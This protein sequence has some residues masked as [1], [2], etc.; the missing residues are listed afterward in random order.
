M[1]S[2]KSADVEKRPA[3]HSAA[4]NITSTGKNGILNKERLQFAYRT[5][6]L[7]RFIDEK[8]MNLLKQG[9]IL[10]HISGP[11][12]EAAQVAIAM[13]MRPGH[14]WSYP[15]YRDLA[16]SLAMGSTAKDILCENM[17]RIEGPSSH[18][19]QMPSHYGDKRYRIVGQS[20]PTG[21][22]Y[23]QAVGTAM[24]SRKEGNDEVTYVS[25][26]EGSDE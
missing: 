6:V 25:S 5:M 15:Y 10:F 18:G 26:G 9:K 24:G 2:K 4:A 13:A 8:E 20:S 19:R 7:A 12:H 22:Q 17:H 23:L 11:G 21:T 14:D 3:E 16:F 1:A